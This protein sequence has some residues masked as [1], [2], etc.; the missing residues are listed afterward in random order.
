[1]T[2]GCGAIAGNVTSDN[3]GPLHLINIKRLAYVVRK[4]EEAFESV[5][6]PQR[7][8]LAT[9]VETYLSSRGI[10]TGTAAAS[11]VTATSQLVDRFLASRQK[12]A[13]PAAPNCPIPSTPVS[14]CGGPS[15]VP[16]VKVVDF[17]CEEDVR[18]AVKESR[19]IY[20]GPRT[21]VTPLARDL[22]EG[23]D[24]LVVAERQK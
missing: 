13:P 1:M 23:S 8:K 17:V 15:V 10:R 22:G 9:A 11:T 12:S 7:D 20:I 5:Q 2:L 24:I 18:Q 14:A 16:A 4:P 6:A 21:I 3:I 19:K